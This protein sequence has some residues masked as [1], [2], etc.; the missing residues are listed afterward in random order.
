MVFYNIGTH[1]PPT[2]QTR[3]DRLEC[4]AL[5]KQIHNADYRAEVIQAV[6]DAGMKSIWK[7]TTFTRSHTLK[8]MQVEVDHQMCEVA[9]LC[10]N[11]SWTKDV[12]IS[13]FWDNLH[14]KEPIYQR[15][16]KQLFEIV[17]F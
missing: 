13:S 6:S 1:R 14:F 4:R 12:D 9:T 17:G 3:V 8:P 5:A 7:T 16:N 11:I 2:P 10:L 15:M